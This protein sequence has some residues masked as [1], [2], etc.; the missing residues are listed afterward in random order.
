M[1]KLIFYLFAITI[2]YCNS[3]FA[4][5][6]Y[7]TENKTNHLSPLKVSFSFLNFEN[8]ILPIT[9]GVMVEGNVATKLF[10]NVQF[11]QGYLRYFFVPKEK[12]ITTQKESKATYFEAGVDFAFSDKIKQGSV[13]VVTESSNDGTYVH[14]KYFMANCDVRKLWL[15]SGGILDYKRAKFVNSDSSYYII[16]DNQT[17]KAPKDYFTH[18]NQNTFAIYAGITSRKIKKAI[19]HSDG[20][21]YRRFF[22]RKFYAH[23]LIGVTNVGKIIYKDETYKITNAKQQPLGYRIGWQW[24]EMGVVTNFEFGKM[25]GVQLETPVEKTQIDNIFVNNPF[26]NYFKLTFHFNIYGGDKNYHLKQVN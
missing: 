19:V 23:A 14:E 2:F 25:P 18:F 8:V 26:Y 5:I 13:K 1:K 7:T 15:L 22:A 11:R 4:Q 10:Y 24:D 16:S 17:I 9:A 12:L 6:Q 20:W 3:S 21:K